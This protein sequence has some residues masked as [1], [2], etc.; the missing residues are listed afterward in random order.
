LR[1]KRKLAFALV[2]LFVIST[3]APV[4]G[5]TLAQDDDKILR[6]AMQQDM[7]NFNNWDLNSNSVWKFYVIGKWC[8]EG[9][10]GLDP[11]GNLYPAQ[12][13]TWTFDDTDSENLTVN[14]TIRQGITFHDG[15]PMDA[16]DV[17]FT[18]LSLRDGTTYASNIIDAFDADG[19][20]TASAD[21]IDGTIDADGDGSYEGI[22]IIDSHNVKMIMGKPYGQFFLMTLGV[23]IIP[24][25]IWT[26]HR[27][28]EGIVD[29]LW[30]TDEEATIGTGPMMYDSGEADVFRRVVVFEDYWGVDEKSPS[31]HWLYPQEVT[32]I[33]FTLYASLDTAILALKSGLVDHIPWTV[34]PGYVPDLIQNPKTD[35]ESISDN[36]YFYLAFNMKREPMNHLAF[37]KAVSHTIDKET[38]VERYMGGYG[39]AGDSSEPPFW[40]DWYNSSVKIYPF[41]VDLAKQE[42]IAGGF[43]GVGTQLRMPVT[44][45]PVAPLVLLTPPADYDPIRI[46]AGELIAKNL[47][48]LGMDIVAK[49]VDFDT[50]VAKMNAFD[51]DMLIIGWSLS[52]DPVGNVF[53]I[54][55]PMASQ[56][57]FAWWP[58]DHE[59]ENPWYNELYGISTRADQESQDMAIQVHELGQ[60]AKESFDR[61]EQ[62]FNTKWAQGIV[63]DA[64]PCN[65]LYYRVNNYAISKTWEGWIP[66]FGELLNVYSL[67]GLT[68]EATTPTIEEV[69]ILLNVPEKLPLGMDAAANVVVFDEEGKPIEGATVTLTGSDATFTPTTGTTDADGTFMFDVMGTKH[70][71]VTIDV[72]VDAGTTASLSRIVQVQAGTPPTY[73]LQAVPDD[74]FLGPGDSTDVMLSV[75]DHN[76]DGISGIDVEL[77]EGLLGYGSV[78]S[79]SVTTDTNGEATMVYTAPASFPMNKHIEVRMS[80]SPVAAEG[81]TTGDINTVTQ[82]LV[83]YNMADSDWHF[84]QIKDVSKVACNATN[85]TT[86]VTI[87]AM[88]EEGNPLEES[89]SISYS[90]DMALVSPMMSV[91]TNASGMAEV[92]IMWDSGA[93]TN[94]TQ[95]WFENTD[96]PNGVGAGAN[97]LFKGATPMELYGGYFTIADTPMIDPDAD[98]NLTWDIMVY[99]LD[100]MP[101]DVDVALIIGEPSDGSSALWT[102]APDY[103]WSSLWDYAGINIFT[104]ADGGV[105]AAGGYF[106]STLMTDQELE[107][108]DG[109]Y[110]TWQEAYDDWYGGTVDELENM[111]PMTIT[112][113]HAQVV[114]EEDS[115][116]LADNIPQLI[117][118]PMAK[119]GFYMTPDYANFWWEMQGE[120][121]WKTEFTMQRT[122]TISSVK[123]DYGTGIVRPFEPGNTSA[124]D[125]WAVDQDG[126]PIEGVD[127]DGW[128]QV[129][130]GS[131]YFDVT[132]GAVTDASGMTS[133]TLMGLDEDGGGN[134]L[135]NPVKQPMYMQ[136]AADY[137]W[138]V[139]TSVE[140]FNMPVQL[141]LSI[142]STPIIQEEGDPATT[143]EIVISV[144]DETG[145]AKEGF[146]VSFGT[147]G[148]SVSEESV[149]TDANGE[150]LV[151]Y[152]LPDI[153]E[154]DPF[155]FGSVSSSVTEIGYG[156]ASAAQ[157]LVSYKPLVNLLPEI[158]LTSHDLT[159]YETQ[160]TAFTIGGTATDDHGVNTITVALDGGSEMAATM[161]DDDW[162]YDL[163]DLTVG[164]HEAVMTVTDIF[165][166]TASLTM[167]FEILEPTVIIPAPEFSDI[168]VAEGAEF[169]EG[170]DVVFSGVVTGESIDTLTIA[171]DAGAAVALTWNSTGNWEHTYTDLAVGDHSVVIKA[172]NT[173]GNASEET[174]G[175][176]MKEKEVEPPDDDDDETDYTWLYI[177]IV[178]IIVLIIVAAVFMSR[179]GGAEPSPAPAAEEESDEYE[180]D[181]EEEEESDEYEDDE[182][183]EEEE[184]KEPEGT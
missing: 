114:V 117:V 66:Y 140:I 74:L 52:S 75:T 147:E 22:T 103:T 171:L 144:V 40:A 129:Y 124:V 116:F 76:G 33:Y 43:T 13:E 42:L 70:A 15:E 160:A 73:F 142:D 95:V 174:I 102:D 146:T 12:A 141:Y 49:P 32:E 111:M 67:G 23:P 17:L 112:G 118:V 36:G 29:I 19:D 105:L 135:S 24:E 169:E 3:V 125:L 115:V 98:T 78:D 14:V 80:L 1:Y 45:K 120:T 130:G 50:L 179:G 55:G 150:A 183:E 77:D 139:F 156:A 123:Y 161:S 58:V 53:D 27:T 101:A 133:A 158:T 68:S 167:S 35:I 184:D 26:D 30:N 90:N 5:P 82:F 18:Y 44:G 20:G 48:S 126:N 99:D 61:D 7:P 25:H 109:L 176:K 54:L 85:D 56:N 108:L 89:I 122:N 81:M 28:P 39:Q 136:A 131:P 104:G 154:G 143:A 16:D 21:E 10:S 2:A 97:L 100:D 83:L 87:M 107:D 64:L 92:D 60:K 137:G 63:S 71:Y 155:I 182:E 157:V 4:V 8:W 178:I 79:A 38:I 84:V 88:D 164:T 65:V 106:V 47:R 127:I 180:D 172:Q 86:T 162:S 11:G 46:K 119:S 57:Y 62:I 170:T 153:V 151:T 110:T 121:A 148:G 168:S 6:I 166:L 51:Y 9:L 94:A 59:Y 31:G 175:F 134:P 159:G 145:A 149:T 181:E 37:R 165:D 113:G 132:A 138:N 34:T 91:D 177:V 93:D 72:D 173:A 96:V 41:D 128:V 69:N 163:A 152:T